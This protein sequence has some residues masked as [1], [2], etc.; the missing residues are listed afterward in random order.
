MMKDPM[1]KWQLLG[2]PRSHIPQK[3]GKTKRAV[4]M[5]TQFMGA[6]EQ[7]KKK[8]KKKKHGFS[9]G[10]LRQTFGV[11]RALWTFPFHHHHHHH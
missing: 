2:I 9:R 4:R 3:T 6:P 1:E 8:K 10:V 5:R 7:K 11:S